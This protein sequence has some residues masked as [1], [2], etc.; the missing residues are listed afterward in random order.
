MPHRTITNIQRNK[1]KNKLRIS[2]RKGRYATLTSQGLTYHLLNGDE[3]SVN[4]N[5]I[6][7]FSIDNNTLYIRYKNGD[8]HHGTHEVGRYPQSLEKKINYFVKTANSFLESS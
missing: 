1:S 3:N 2:F 4:L 6:D 5:N 8:N 7:G